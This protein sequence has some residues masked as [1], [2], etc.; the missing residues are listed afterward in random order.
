MIDAVAF[1]VD[2]DKNGPMVGGVAPT[3]AIERLDTYQ[4]QFDNRK[5]KWNSYVD[6]ESLFGLPVTLYPELEQT[7]KELEFL[8]RLYDL[9]KDVISTIDN[10]SEILWTDV[11]ANIEQMNEQVTGFQNQ[12]RKLPKALRDWTA[13][14][15]LRKKID[16]FLEILPAVQS[17]A[18]PS[19][20]QRHWV[21]LQDL[22]SV[23][24]DMS[25]D[26]FKLGDLLNS[27][28]IPHLDEIEELTGGANKEAQVETKLG[29]IDIDW[30]DQ[31][32]VFVEFKTKGFCVLDA[33]ATGELVEKL[34][35]SQMALGSMATNRYSAPFKTAVA[36]W[37]AK[38]STVGDVVEMWLVVQNMWI[39]MEAVFCGG[40]IV[41]QLPLE[42][43]R[44]NQ[45]DKAFLK[46]VSAA[47]ETRHV[48]IARFPNPSTHCLPI[49]DV[50]HFF[51]AITGG[52]RLLRRRYDFDPA[53]VSHGPAGA[54]SKK[55]DCVS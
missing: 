24:L 15:D 2:W 23:T 16:D 32:F 49:Q 19:M 43:K 18:A 51:F 47:V 54:V 33:A 4:K 8:N 7:E 30:E 37:T 12:C 10:Y 44:F 36:E 5:R 6:G 38:L 39:Y 27:N 28:L 1:R 26:T 40:D 45:I 20:R 48:R 21:A 3:E 46:M 53:A 42:A 35:D 14:A 29:Q 22:T 13:Y 31:N 50:N 55:P 25:E 34:E 9:Y 17:L 52:E 11:V 41:K